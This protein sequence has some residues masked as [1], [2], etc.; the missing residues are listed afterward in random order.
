MTTQ[1][2]AQMI[3]GIGI[4]Y[5]YYQFDE[6]TAQEPPFI[7]FYYPASENFNADD[8]VFKEGAQLNIELYTKEKDFDLE[9]QIKQ[10]LVD[11]DLVYSWSEIYLDTEKLHMTNFYTEVYFNG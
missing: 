1:D 6:D 9:E 4:P 2:I 11:N 10:A 5:A 8:T 3:A 7:C